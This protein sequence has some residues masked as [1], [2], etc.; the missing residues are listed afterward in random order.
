MLYQH[1]TLEHCKH[2]LTKDSE[3]FWCPLDFDPGHQCLT[4]I[5]HSSHSEI[6]QF[7]ACAVQQREP[8]ENRLE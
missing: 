7:P 4:G 1:L 2:Q 3:G 5:I 8:Y 6:G